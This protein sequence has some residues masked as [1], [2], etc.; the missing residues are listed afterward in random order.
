MSIKEI[1][2]KYGEGVLTDASF[3]LEETKIVIPV[4]PAIDIGLRGGIPEGSVCTFS[5]KAGSGKST[6]A[7]QIAANAQR[8][9]NGARKIYYADVECRLKKSNLQGIHGLDCSPDK[10]SVIR[11][12][13]NKILSAEDYLNIVL[14]LIKSQPRSIFIID[15]ASALC[16]LGEMSDEVR[17]DFR[18]NGPKLLANFC[19][20]IPPLM[21]LNK[22]ILMITQHLITD[23][24]GKGVGYHEDGGVKVTH[25]ADIR[26]RIKYTER[27]NVGSGE[28]EKQIGKVLHWGISKSPYGEVDKLESYLRYG[29]GL[30][31][32]F[33]Y[34]NLA[35]DLGIIKKGG[36]WYSYGEEKW[37]GQ[38]KLY[39]AIL[40]NKTLFEE[41][42]G[43]ISL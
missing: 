32:V 16:G 25:Q 6:T 12:T 9:E 42:K 4:S 10:F 26:M 15:S 30:D 22:Q 7:L 24:S 33:E 41:I 29:Y 11:S 17:S 8:K 39:N 37:Q 31:D 19:R 20:H 14:T 18:N 1:Q 34:I 36:A 27:W 28:N 2:K 35:I 13:E 38:E 21:L 40:E 3:L 23:T 43:K 5:G